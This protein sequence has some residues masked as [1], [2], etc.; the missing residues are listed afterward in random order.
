MF[1]ISTTATAHCLNLQY[2]QYIIQTFL[3]VMC[4]AINIFLSFSVNAT[5][6][7]TNKKLFI[8]VLLT[9]CNLSQL[10]SK[11]AK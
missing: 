5:T 8:D 6:H 7:F 2:I 11:Q 10:N 1:Y 9:C 3:L 4:L